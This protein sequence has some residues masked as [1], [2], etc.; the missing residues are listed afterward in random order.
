MSSPPKDLPAWSHPLCDLSGETAAPEPETE[1]P[2]SGW[3]SEKS[4]R[5]EPSHS[6]IHVRREG[7]GSSWI[8]DSNWNASSM[9]FSPLELLP[10]TAL[11]TS[12]H[13]SQP[14]L[15]STGETWKSF[16]SILVL[17]L[18]CHFP[19]TSHLY[20]SKQYISH[21][22]VPNLSFLL[23]DPLHLLNSTAL[24]KTSP[25]L[26]MRTQTPS[27]AHGWFLGQ[28]GGGR[29]PWSQHDLLALCNFPFQAP[30]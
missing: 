12:Q 10:K 15:S 24:T 4:T 14:W 29:T 8:T 7:F 27:L 11:P 18:I 3:G 1:L 17:W 6:T 21:Q 19:N 28:L 22:T 5:A 25:H 16:K 20:C 26:L 2:R 23:L 30:V 9:H 13:L